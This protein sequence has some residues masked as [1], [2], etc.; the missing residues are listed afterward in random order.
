MTNCHS[1][2]KCYLYYMNPSA[3]VNSLEVPLFSL[4]ILL[5]RDLCPKSMESCGIIP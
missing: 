5:L 3:C 2:L 1:S 4:T